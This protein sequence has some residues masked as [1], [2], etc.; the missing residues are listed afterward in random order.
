MQQFTLWK[1]IT[2]KIVVSLYLELCP[3]PKCLM[4]IQ[5]HY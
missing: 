5:W 1:I 2:A 4:V 3:V